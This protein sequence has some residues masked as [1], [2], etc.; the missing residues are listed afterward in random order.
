MGRPIAAGEA[1]KPAADQNI[2]IDVL[3]ARP[4]MHSASSESDSK[5]DQ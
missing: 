2:A 3:S 1:V 4:K 5:S